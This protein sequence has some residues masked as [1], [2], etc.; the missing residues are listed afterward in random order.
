MKFALVIHNDWPRW[1]AMTEEEQKAA[2]LTYST[3]DADLRAAGFPVGP[4]IVL[5]GA[6]RAVVVRGGEGG[7]QLT[8]RG[9]FTEAAE[10]VGGFWVIDVP[11]EEVAVHWAQRLQAAVDEPVEVRTVTEY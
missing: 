1:A 5:N 11:D 10:Q 7:G 9:P 2:E 4:T 6:S 8:T 3:F